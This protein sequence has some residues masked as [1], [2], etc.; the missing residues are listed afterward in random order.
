MKRFLNILIILLLF[1]DTLISIIKSVSYL[2]EFLCIIGILFI[3]YLITVR[4]VKIYFTSYEIISMIALILFIVITLISNVKFKLINLDLA[5]ISLIMTLKG[6]LIYFIVRVVFK[7]YKIK[8][9]DFKFA[10]V[11]LEYGLY[12]YTIIGVLNIPLNFLQQRGERFG[13]STVAIGFSHTTELA[14]F[15]IVSMLFV[16]YYKTVTNSKNKILVVLA[17]GILV[18]LSGRSKA[19]GFYVLFILLLISSKFIKKIKIRKIILFVPILIFIGYERIISEFINGVRGALYMGAYQIANDYFPLGSG[20]GTYG[21]YISR[22]HYSIL[23][24]NYGLSNIWGLS[25]TMPSYIADTYWAM[26][27]GESGWIGIFLIGLIILML[28]WQCFKNYEDKKIKILSVS[29]LLYSLIASIAEP[30]YSSNK[31]AAYF[32]LLALLIAPQRNN[33]KLEQN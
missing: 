24:Y 6:Y 22:I 16:L 12:L 33:N 27:L 19:V 32:F 20:F 3:C 21:S 11:F 8:I 25:P 5:L 15:S 30:I 14:F 18:F 28:I 26:I 9:F 10:S 7:T 29:L 31:C 2:D 23:Y 13:I 1:Q 4:R 17:S